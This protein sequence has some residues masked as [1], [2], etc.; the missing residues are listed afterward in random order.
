[1]RK[2]DQSYSPSASE[3]SDLMESLELEY[4]VIRAIKALPVSFQRF[5]A[6]WSPKL[7][8]DER[9]QRAVKIFLD[10]QDCGERLSVYSY[11]VSPNVIGALHS[12][13]ATTVWLAKEIGISRQGLHKGLKKGLSEDR[14]RQVERAMRRLG[15]EFGF[16]IFK[17]LNPYE[18]S[19]SRYFEPLKIGVCGLAPFEDPRAVYNNQKQE[20]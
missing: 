14:I 17:I 19:Y 16:Q 7:S 18:A 10:L 11:A 3:L 1:M 2:V 15:G 5:W 13:G 6:L 8:T 4:R 12:V 9:K 20:R